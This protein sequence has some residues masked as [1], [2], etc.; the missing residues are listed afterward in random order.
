MS[1]ILDL[2]VTKTESFIT[3]RINKRRERIQN[4]K[5][6]HPV[7]DWLG[8]FLWAIGF[9]LIVNQFFMQAY[10]IPSRSMD[11]T[12]VVGDRVLVDKFSYGPE[13][14]PGLFKT[15]GISEPELGDVV[16]FENPEYKSRG[17][18]FDLLQRVVFM[19]T[20]STVDIDKD[21]DGNPAHH[22]L[23]KRIAVDGNNFA[24]FVNGDLYIKTADDEKFLPEDNYLSK[25]KGFSHF[26]RLIHPDIYNEVEDLIQ[27]NVYTLQNSKS[28]IY[29]NDMYYSN[30]TNFKYLS[31]ISPSRIDYYQSYN[32]WDMGIYV[33]KDWVLLL[34]D[35]RDNSKDGRF[36]GL[37]HK[38]EILGKAKFRFWPFNRFGKVEEGRYE[39][40][41]K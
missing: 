4:Q 12:L 13:L 8:A 30:L 25:H 38:S 24:R 3:N 15:E 9:V 22:F 16:I 19:L 28:S 31:H 7:L 14:L 6:L 1:N 27:D 40:V 23:I 11:T 2:T 32:M 33:P 41:K 34:G 10:V 20:L 26:T 35:N 39:K 17:A 36:F 21:A 5:K 29:R 37:V 18:F